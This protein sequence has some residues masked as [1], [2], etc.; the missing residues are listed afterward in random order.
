LKFGYVV[1]N[2]PNLVANDYK[3]HV[4]IN[5]VVTFWLISTNEWKKKKVGAHSLTHN[6]SRVGGH[7]RGLEWD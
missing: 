6:T 5:G 1:A 2:I 3:L 4:V 7:A